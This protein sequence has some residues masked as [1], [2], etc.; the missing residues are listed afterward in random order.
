MNIP[1]YTSLHNLYMYIM[2]EA[3]LDQGASE[4]KILADIVNKSK[5]LQCQ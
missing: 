1:L 5:I 4:F 2:K 3:L